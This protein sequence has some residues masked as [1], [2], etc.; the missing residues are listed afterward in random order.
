MLFFEYFF[1]PCISEIEINKNNL[2][3][4]SAVCI[5]EKSD[6]D[7][8][9][10]ISE[11]IEIDE[12]FF[13]RGGT[14]LYYEKKESNNDLNGWFLPSV[15][16]G[17]YEITINYSGFFSDKNN[18]YHELDMKKGFV[19]LHPREGDCMTLN[20]KTLEGFV[21]NSFE[22]KGSLV[23]LCDTGNKIF[24]LSG[25]EKVIEYENLKIITTKSK[26]VHQSWPNKISEKINIV[27]GQMGFM[28]E[29]KLILIEGDSWFSQKGVI[30]IPENYLEN[31]LRFSE[32]S[33]HLAYQWQDVKKPIEEDPVGRV[34]HSY[35]DE[36][37]TPLSRRIGDR[38]HLQ[39]TNGKDTL[40]LQGVFFEYE[41]KYQQKNCGETSWPFARLLKTKV[42]RLADGYETSL[43]FDWDGKCTPILNVKISNSKNIL[44]NNITLHPGTSVHKMTSKWIPRYLEIDPRGFFPGG[45]ERDKST[46]LL[47]ES[48]AS[49]NITE[50]IQPIGMIASLGPGGIS[51]PDKKSI[52]LP[53]G[54]LRDWNQESLLLIASKNETFIISSSK[55][56]LPAIDTSL[57][58]WGWVFFEE[59]KPARWGTNTGS[60]MYKLPI[61]EIFSWGN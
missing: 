30:V 33:K 43:H 6:N 27:E 49:K 23:F 9:F 44:E 24:Q 11:K 2:I 4:G 45:L 15:P 20:L 50:W 1:M 13:T 53:D 21:V 60:K 25:N 48:L 35:I 12:I 41:Q 37:T 39:K 7:V 8:D 19:P 16:G 32:I 14:N 38:A 54:S 5:I 36:K 57:L 17:V 59:E 42:A 22:E 61:P 31:N 3:K 55:T 47:F 46:P 56:K 18:L 51:W 10:Y 58:D 26:S 34:V 29:D 52:Q 40:R 28:N